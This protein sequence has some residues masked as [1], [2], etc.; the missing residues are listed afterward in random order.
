MIVL[1]ILLD[2]RQQCLQG[3]RVGARRRR[4]QQRP[5]SER[6]WLGFGL[7]EFAM[8]NISAAADD[9]HGHHIAD[10]QQ[11]DTENTDFKHSYT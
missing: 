4:R 7:D 10:R 9:P 2:H 8:Q 11:N 6:F 3:F 1:Q 5:Y